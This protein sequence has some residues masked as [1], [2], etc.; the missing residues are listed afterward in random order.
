MGILKQGF[1][2]IGALLA[3][4]IAYLFLWPVSITPAEWDAPQNQGYKGEFAVNNELAN[5]SR[6]SIGDH[7]GPED[8]AARMTQ[9]GLRLYVS[10]Q[11]GDILEINPAADTHRTFAQTGGVPLGIEFDARDNLIVADAHKGLLSIT[12]DGAVSLLTN[13]VNDTPILY[14]DDVD[15]AENG[16]IYFSDASTKFGAK[17]N[18]STLEAS[19]LEIF[20]HGKTGRI[21]AYDPAAKATYEIAAHISFANGIAAAPDGQSILYVETGEYRIMRLYVDG[22]R[23]GETEIIRDNLPGFPDNI[24]PAPPLADGTPSYFIGLVSPRSQSVDDLAGAPRRRKMIWRLPAI[25]KP[26]AKAY[27]HLIHMDGNG[28]I[29]KSWQDPLGDYA[30]VTGGIIAGDHL[31]VSSLSAAGLGYRA[32]PN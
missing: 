27:S 2:L 19:L 30:M 11:N 3:L 16:I 32:A 5:L 20:E 26:K 22:P 10:S 6:L 1:I 13:H 24:N 15:I 31:Y 18:G 12:P 17:D 21:L 9:A 25:M 23:L 14:A 4:L 7:H 29:L 28:N 8:V